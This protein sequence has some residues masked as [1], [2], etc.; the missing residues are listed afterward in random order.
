MQVVDF[1]MCRFRHTDKGPLRM[2]TNSPQLAQRV[3]WRSE[4]SAT[5]RE[6]YEYEG[7]AGWTA[8]MCKAIR[9]GSKHEKRE[10]YGKTIADL[11]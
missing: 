1:N 5:P 4:P 2:I 6:E 7:S 3:I 8:T 10:V 9:A 11:R